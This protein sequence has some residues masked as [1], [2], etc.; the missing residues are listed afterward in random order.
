MKTTI[1]LRMNVLSRQE[2]GS[3]D[4]HYSADDSCAQSA[5]DRSSQFASHG[6]LISV[7]WVFFDN[8]VPELVGTLHYGI[9]VA[10]KQ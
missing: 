3:R 1:G 6:H 10:G 7:R 8:P 9:E 5:G 2:E 4:S